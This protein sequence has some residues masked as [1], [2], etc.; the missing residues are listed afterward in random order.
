MNGDFELLDLLYIK[1][2]RAQ[3]LLELLGNPSTPEAK[4]ER[5]RRELTPLDYITADK[6]NCL[7]MYFSSGTETNNLYVVRGFLNLD[8]FTKSREDLK[9]IQRIVSQVMIDNDIFRVSFHNESSDTKGIFRYTEKYR[10]L[11]WA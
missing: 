3:G 7:A 8:Y 6:V 1:L 2:Y 9:K 4:N 11:C 5:I 10:P